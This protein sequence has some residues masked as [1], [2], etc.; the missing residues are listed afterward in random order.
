MEDVNDL[1]RRAYNLVSTS[2]DDLNSSMTFYTGDVFEH[3]EIIK[4]G[5]IICRRRGEK[6]KI[7][8]LERKLKK[9]KAVTK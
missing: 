8:I 2:V 9:M 3:V 6:T 7:K 4:R 1:Q 5:L